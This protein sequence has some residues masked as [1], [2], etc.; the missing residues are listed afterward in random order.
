M[1]DKDYEVLEGGDDSSDV[2]DH[3]FDSTVKKTAQEH[4]SERHLQDERAVSS[5]P[6]K[7]EDHRVEGGDDEWDEDQEGA[8]LEVSGEEEE[9]AEEVEEGA[10]EEGEEL[11]IE[12]D[13]TP[14]VGE[15][16]EIDGKEYTVE[17][18][19]GDEAT[20]ADDALKE[21]M[22]KYLDEHG[23][24]KYVIKGREY[25]LRDLSP[26]E[27]KQRFSLAGRAYQV[28]EEGATL[29]KQ[30]DERERLA[31]EGAERS[32]EIMRR[33]GEVT[34]REKSELPDSLKV[35]EMDSDEVKSLK[36]MNAELYNKVGTL[37]KGYEEQSF[38]SQERELFGQLDSLEK[39]FPVLSREQVVAVKA[40]YPD[41]DIRTIAENS[42]N[43][44]TSD[45]T[46]KKVLEY[47]PD[48]VRGIKEEAIKEYLAGKQKTKKVAR[49]KSSST[50][51]SKSSS[52]KTKIPRTLDEIEDHL[53]DYKLG[54][55]ELED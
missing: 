44:Q 17:A 46:V 14:K 42:H 26:Q 13:E 12:L 19:E 24:T 15:V 20:T 23:G 2:T 41:A 38:K 52:R 54:L 25:D 6:P 31:R 5:E 55:K 45:A 9:E 51:S 40:F 49:R 36:Q 10:E 16:L 4:M 11:E 18:V 30:I 3:P 50:V 33:Y 8:D 34:G 39:E 22:I 35:D 1:A 27:I 32:Q 48:I 53:E 7:S 28:M 47:R 37:E 21:D 29:R 43:N